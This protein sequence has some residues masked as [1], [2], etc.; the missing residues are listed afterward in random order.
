MGS[1]VLASEFFGPITAC[2]QSVWLSQM[3]PVLFTDGHV[4]FSTVE[5]ALSPDA[6]CSYVW[7]LLPSF[8][9]SFAQLWGERGANQQSRSEEH[10]I[11]SKR[12]ESESDSEIEECFLAPR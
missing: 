3:Q 11:L 2:A 8:P 5:R 1:R 10:G 12:E 9:L 6:F 7:F 4:L